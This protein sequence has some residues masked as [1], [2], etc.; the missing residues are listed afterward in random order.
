MFTIIVFLAVL[1]IKD[2]SQDIVVDNVNVVLLIAPM[3]F[4]LALIYLV[5]EF[6]K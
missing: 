4:D 3:A 1:I 6:I 5:L 2:R